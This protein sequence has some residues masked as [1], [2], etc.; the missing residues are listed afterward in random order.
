MMSIKKILVANRGEIAIR[1]M[2]SAK[3]LGIKTVAVYSEADKLLPHASYADEA[4]NIGPAAASES[5][6]VHDKI[7]DAC[8]QTGA[9][10]IHP[11]YGFLSENAA[12]AERVEKEGLIFIGPSPEAI[13][14]MGDKL[15]SKQTVQK[16]NV[17]LVPGM[18]EPINDV[19]KAKKVANEIGYPVMI[20]A[21]AGGGGKGMRI[22]NDPKDFEEQMDRAM[23]EARNSFGNDEVFIEKFISSPKHIE[24]QIL[25]DQHGNI[26]HLFERECSI[27]RRHQ[28]VVEEAPSALLTPERRKQIGEAAVNVAKSCSYY[29]AGTVEF[30]A[31]ENLD[32]YFLEM[33]TRLQV[34]HPVTELIT[35]VDLVKEQIAIANGEKISFSQDDL[36]IKGHS[37][38]VRVY[39][40][41]PEN[42][43]LPDTGKL[44]TYIRPQGAG[45]RV[46][47]GYEQGQEVSIY[48]DPMIA[49]LI[50]YGK[51][52]TEAIDRMRRAIAEY[53]ITGV[54]TTL[55]FCDYVLGHEEF[56]DGSFTTKFVESHYSPEVLKK[57]VSKES[58]EIA[59][60]IANELVNKQVKKVST[61]ERKVVQSKWKER[62][63]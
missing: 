23:S 52:R 24:V 11:G 26:V 30:I 55:T 5:Y 45:V 48:Y 27:Q 28:K 33:N 41:D 7:I 49:K 19:E 32:F 35:G 34:E 43:F 54:K 46:D 39:A 58:A 44:K 57:E 36:T 40:E 16:F 10:A 31:D 13:R 17:P 60:L 53:Q 2:R 51:D 6:L 14:I 37:L 18:D 42:N 47:D 62:L 1:V 38:E 15:T 63:K 22:V 3:E 21:S 20:K 61:E 12:F 4:V 50:T 9:D 56:I 25:G 59:A 8:K 29:G